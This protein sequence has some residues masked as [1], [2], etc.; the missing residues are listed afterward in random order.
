MLSFLILLRPFIV[1]ILI[2]FLSA[3]GLLYIKARYDDY[4]TLKENNAGLTV[5]INEQQKAFSQKEEELQTI[6]VT[7]KKQKEQTAILIDDIEKLQNKFNKV[8]ADGRKRDIG[9]LLLYKSGLVEK[10]INKGTWKVFRC[11]EDISTNEI[12]NNDCDGIINNNP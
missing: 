11:F 3:G 8:K 5:A 1:H 12:D 4:Q 9:N 7:Y 6:V 2:I 10:I